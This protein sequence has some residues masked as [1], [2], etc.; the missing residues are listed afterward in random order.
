MRKIVLILL[1]FFLLQ[2][3]GKKGNPEYQGM[4]IEQNNILNLKT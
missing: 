4:R 1:I 2:S 3:C